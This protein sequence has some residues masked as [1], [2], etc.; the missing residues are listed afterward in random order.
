M[1]IKAMR[2][3]HR[4]MTQLSLALC[5]LWLQ[6]DCSSVEQESQPCNY[7]PTFPLCPWLSL[8]F[9]FLH[10]FLSWINLCYWHLILHSSIYKLIQLRGFLWEMLYQGDVTRIKQLSQSSEGG[11]TLAHI[12]VFSSSHSLRQALYFKLPL[13]TTLWISL[14]NA[15]NTHWC[16]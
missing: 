16:E 14:F 4:T 3:K 11:Y 6:T 9:V 8:G 5:I 12:S 1:V 13:E 2:A 7:T 10:K 15:V